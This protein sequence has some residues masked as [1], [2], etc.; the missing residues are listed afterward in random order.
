MCCQECA[1]IERIGEP[2]GRWWQ[3]PHGAPRLPPADQHGGAGPARARRV[4]VRRACGCDHPQ[5]AARRQRGHDGAGGAAHRSTGDHRRPSLGSRRHHH[6][7]RR[8]RILCRRRPLPAQADDEGGVAS[9]ASGLRPC[10]LHAATVEQADHRRSPRHGIRRWVRDR[11]Q[12]GLH[13]R[14]RRG[15]IRSAGSD[16]RAVRRRGRPGLPSPIASSG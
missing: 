9:S 3:Y 16:G 14:L 7:S 5:S 6:G 4:R 1:S 13:H 8:P 15:R 10:P 12:H 11:R 2:D